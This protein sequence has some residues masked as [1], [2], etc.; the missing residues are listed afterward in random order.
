LHPYATTGKIIVSYIQVRGPL[1]HFVTSLFFTTRI[2]WP[3]AQPPS[4]R[5]TPCQ[6]SATAYSIHTSSQLPSIS[7]RSMVPILNFSWRNETS[8]RT[9]RRCVASW[10]TEP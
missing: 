10:E 7:G 8:R 3:H 2:C 4:L 9:C 6:L 5:T 1:W